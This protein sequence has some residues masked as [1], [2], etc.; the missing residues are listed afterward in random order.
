MVEPEDTNLDPTLASY[1]TTHSPAGHC[2]TTFSFTHTIIIIMAVTVQGTE[3]TIDVYTWEEKRRIG[4]AN[5]RNRGESC[6]S[7]CHH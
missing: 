3:Y 6:V 1:K 7:T 4:V 2:A 5:S